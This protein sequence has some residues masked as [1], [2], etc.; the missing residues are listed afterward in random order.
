MRLIIIYLLAFLA[1][2]IAVWILHLRGLMP[3]WLE[4]VGPLFQC[5][6]A[7]GIGGAIYCLRAVYLNACVRKNWDRDWHVWYYIRPLVSLISGGISWLF[8]KAGL[9]VL[10]AAQAVAPSN[11]GFLALAF[12]A[13]YNVDKF[14]IKLEQISESTWGIEKSR[15]STGERKK[16]REEH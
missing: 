7:G 16:E 5:I 6:L 3:H 1:S 15:S 12:I 4:D 9:L 10:D 11:I 2:I 8:L 13:G 14:M